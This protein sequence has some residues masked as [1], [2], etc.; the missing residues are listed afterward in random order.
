MRE[1]P[2]SPPPERFNLGTL[3]KVLVL[4]GALFF[5]YQAADWKLV[6]PTASSTTNTPRQL[7]SAPVQAPVRPSVQRPVALTDTPR[8]TKCVVNAKTSYSDAPCPYGAVGSEI[9]TYANHNLM[10]AVRPEPSHQTP[11]PAHEE[12]A[13]AQIY[14]VPGVISQKTE[15]ESLNTQIVQWDAEA[16]QPHSAQMQDWIKDQ[17][18]RARDRQFR[19]HCA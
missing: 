18:K 19:I 1:H 5:L 2:F 10:A 11:A 15:C 9:T 7:V 12:V 6:Q 8:I 3:G 14:Q 17:R 16:R 13:I 4:V